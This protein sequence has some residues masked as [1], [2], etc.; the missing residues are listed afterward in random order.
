M[1]ALTQGCLQRLAELLNK[2]ST[3]ALTAFILLVILQVSLALHKVAQD[4]NHDDQN[5]NHDDIPDIC[6]FFTLTHFES[7]KFYTRKVRKFM[8][9]MPRDKTA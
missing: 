5:D 9:N 4:N 8:T 1:M 6:L 3:K 7:W 2:V